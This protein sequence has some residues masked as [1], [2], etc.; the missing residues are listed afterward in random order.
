MLK[1][2]S[3]KNTTIKAKQNESGIFQDL[4]MLRVTYVEIL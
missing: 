2:N 4:N 3:L 1:F